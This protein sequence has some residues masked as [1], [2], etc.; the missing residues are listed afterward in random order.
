MQLHAAAGVLIKETAPS[1][2]PSIR[3]NEK[4]RLQMLNQ[5]AGEAAG[6]V[7]PLLASGKPES[8]LRSEGNHHRLTLWALEHLVGQHG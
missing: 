3:K 1:P 6:I 7:L 5:P 8:A 2:W 4:R